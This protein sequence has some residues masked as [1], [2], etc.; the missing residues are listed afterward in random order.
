LFLLHADACVLLGAWPETA[1]LPAP[2]L[3][4]LHADAC[5]LSGA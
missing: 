5:V 2:G 4:L 1:K 3:S